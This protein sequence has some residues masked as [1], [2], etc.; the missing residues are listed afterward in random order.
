M[1]FRVASQLKTYTSHTF[2]NKWV[3]GANPKFKTELGCRVCW[4]VL[5]ENNTTSCLHIASWNLP[6]VE[7]SNSF[8]NRTMG[9]MKGASDTTFQVLQN[10]SVINCKCCKLLVMQ[11]AS[12]ANCKCCKLQIASVANCKLQVLQSASVA[13]CK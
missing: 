3:W 12:V 11:I 13:K 8:T 1:L 7:I 6:R 2:L 5:K 9:A 10:A 4:S